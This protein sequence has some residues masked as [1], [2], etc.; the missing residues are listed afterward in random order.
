MADVFVSYKKEDRPLAE[1]LV[2]ALRAA[3]KSVWWDEALNP[4]QAWDAMIERE[5]A[6]ARHV[7][8]LWT[9]RSVQSD[10]VRSEALYAQDHGKLIP[11][12]GEACTLPLAF[13]LRQAVDL[14]AGALD[15]SNPQ[16]AKLVDWISGSLDHDAAGVSEA[17]AATSA[18]LPGNAAPSERWLGPARRR[19]V[20]IGALVAVVAAVGLGFVLLRGHLGGPAPQPAVVI[21]PL[22]TANA[23][24]LPPSFAKDVSDEMFAGFSSSSRISPVLGDGARR[25][26]AY[27]LT[28]DVVTAGDK[29]QVFA[30]LYAPAI[31][32]PVMTLKLEEPADGKNLP[33]KFGLTLAAL[34]RCVATASDSIGSKLTTLPPAA[35]GPWSRFCQQ[36]FVGPAST[37]TIAAGLRAVTAEAPKFANGWSNFA[38]QLYLSS[39]APG[40]DRAALQ[41]EALKAA[42]RALA[43]DP[44][45]AKSL[46]VKSW[47]TVG[48]LAPPKAGAEVAQLHDFPAW[49][50]LALKSIRVRPSDCGCEVPQYAWTLMMF[51]RASVALPLMDQM[52][53]TDPTDLEDAGDR[54]VYQ[55]IAG[56]SDEA[57]T[58]L[59]A[60]DGKLA[61]EKFHGMQFRS[62]LMRGD[63]AAVRQGLDF[64]RSGPDRDALPPIL[65]ALARHDAVGARAAA[66]P[67]LA[68]VARHD[69][70]GMT[71]ITALA[72]AGY[73]D[74]AA[75][76][77]QTLVS[78]NSVDYMRFAFAPPFVAMRKTPAF[79]AL[80]EK[81]GLMDYWRLPGHRPD[82]CNEPDPA[83]LCA[84]VSKT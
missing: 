54:A 67:L 24:G 1:R 10:W 57:L 18:P 21:D 43:L 4:T 84:A 70:V 8:V 5:I 64:V 6:A 26:K 68:R 12:I 81:L 60:L 19:G 47:G 17:T 13:R 23:K 25:P 36:T 48:Y 46:V 38:E 7:I 33:L 29:V 61:D 71:A 63:W 3:G 2:A 74:E 34:T 51:G 45:N 20:A 83:A 16:W 49:E 59:A 62:A 79:A 32:A 66:A 40:A 80:V 72:S 50:A 52:V 76:G 73:P 44:A 69:V 9:P 11:V 22:V 14:S 58:A 53:T 41:A 28:G 75:Q 42:D 31:D 55:T 65:D 37:A 30:K 35:F 27:Q 77:L 82:F 39:K 15:D 78:V 56:R